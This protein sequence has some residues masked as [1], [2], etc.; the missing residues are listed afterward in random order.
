MKYTVWYT[1]GDDVPFVWDN[2]ETLEMA[3]EYAEAVK[4][5][6]EFDNVWVEATS[7][8]LNNY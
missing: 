3:K 7:I 6:Y 5:D 1:Q 2:Y 4:E 8:L